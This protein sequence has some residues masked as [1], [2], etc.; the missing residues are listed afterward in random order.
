LA[1]HAH[2][3]RHRMMPGSHQARLWRQATGQRLRPPLGVAVA[4][5]SPLVRGWTV[6]PRA[7][8]LAPRAPMLRLSQAAPAEAGAGVLHSL[9]PAKVANLAHLEVTPG[10]YHVRSPVIP[11]TGA[12]RVLSLPWLYSLLALCGGAVVHFLLML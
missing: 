10:I 3:E 11:V 12:V 4:P 6:T 5:F 7:P 9:P 8:A 1:D 2:P